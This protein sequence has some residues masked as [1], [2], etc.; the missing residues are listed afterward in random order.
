[1]HDGGTLAG[2]AVAGGKAFFSRQTL[3]APA[4]A[5]TATLDGKTA[6][7]ITHFTDATTK[8]IALGEVQEIEFEG[9]RGDTVQSTSCCRRASTRRRS[10][11]SCT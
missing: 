6:A 7:A 3:S 8:D 1:M 2:F 9:A 5:W 10:T 11:R 4:E